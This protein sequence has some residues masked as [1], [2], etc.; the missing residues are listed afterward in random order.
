MALVIQPAGSIEASG[1]FSG[2]VYSRN[3]AGQYIRG[4]RIPV[5]PR[6]NRVTQV[7]FDFQAMNRQWQNQ[8]QSVRDAFNDF[9]DTWGVPGR[10]GNTIKLTGQNWYIGLNTRLRIAGLNQI[11]TPPLNPQSAFTPGLSL[12]QVSLAAP[13]MLSSTA[14]LTDGNA[15][16]LY[17]TGAMPQSSNFQKPSLRF[18]QVITAT[19]PGPWEALPAAAIP[20]GGA[21][22]QFEYFAM[23][24]SGRI[25]PK[26]RENFD[27]GIAPE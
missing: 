23:D 14:T 19:G 3:R 6:T 18:D 16:W 20:E 10:L 11:T 2:T 21:R 1:K 17:R 4:Y 7:R 5:Q 27:A 24:A 26:I 8:P 22:F 25:T 9:G 13:V 15:I 12:S